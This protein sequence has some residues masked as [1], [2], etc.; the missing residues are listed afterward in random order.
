MA[1]RQTV[2]GLRDNALFARSVKRLY[3]AERME[4]ACDRYRALYDLHSKTYGDGGDLK[5]VV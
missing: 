4:Y 3:G 2:N 5:S 1:D